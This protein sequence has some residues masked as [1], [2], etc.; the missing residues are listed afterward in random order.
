MH[1]FLSN[2]KIRITFE[3][4]KII[5]LFFLLLFFFTSTGRGTFLSLISKHWLGLP[6]QSV[7]MDVETRKKLKATVIQT[8]KKADLQEMTEFKLRAAASAELGIDLST[9]ANK[10]LVRDLVESFLLSSI[11]EMAKGEQ[12]EFRE[13]EKQS[14]HAKGIAEV[15]NGADEEE[16]SFD[17]VKSYY[18]RKNAVTRFEEGCIVFIYVIL[19]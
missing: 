18:L 12:V 3:Q 19:F 10:K 15:N 6:F 4:R 13:E 8:L 11:Q 17:K 16:S 7:G 9:W 2:N 1:S 5:I 14:L